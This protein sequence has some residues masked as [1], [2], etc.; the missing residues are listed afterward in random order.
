[1]SMSVEELLENTRFAPGN[2]GSLHIANEFLMF[3]PYPY[4]IE[5]ITELIK[6]KAGPDVEIQVEEK[7]T[8]YEF[9]W[10]VK[11]DQQKYH[12][13]GKPWDEKDKEK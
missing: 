8:G 4:S 11:N 7:P 3:P 1:M 13:F 10:S 12:N 6:E 5:S 2:F 9:R